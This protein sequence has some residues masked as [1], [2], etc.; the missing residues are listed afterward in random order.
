MKP[1][2]SAL[3]KLL[4]LAGLTSFATGALAAPSPARCPALVKQ[5]EECRAIAEKRQGL[6]PEGGSSAE[7]RAL[8][9]Q[10][11]GK[12]TRSP[13]AAPRKAKAKRGKAKR[14]RAKRK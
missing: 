7:C 13:C 6:C 1:M 3:A 2:I 8:S 11:A 9:Q 14:V 10:I 12:C 5:D 4:L